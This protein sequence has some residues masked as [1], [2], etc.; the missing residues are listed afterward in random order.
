MNGGFLYTLFVV[1]KF[2]VLWLYNFFSVAVIDKGQKL[3]KVP[4][5]L[6]VDI[7]ERIWTAKQCELLISLAITK[8]Y[9]YKTGPHL[10]SV[11]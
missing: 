10:A 5:T 2:K 4:P 7:Q 11:R 9:T 8:R 3:I 1:S 6:Q